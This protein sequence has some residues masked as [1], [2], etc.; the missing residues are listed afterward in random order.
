MSLHQGV[1]Q[2]VGRRA[3]IRCVLG[4]IDKS[5]RLC[6]GVGIVSH[7][8][9]QAR[10][11]ASVEHVLGIRIRMESDPILIHHVTR[12]KYTKY[13]GHVTYVLLSRV[14]G[15]CFHF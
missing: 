5:A 6:Q 9:R 11:H 4:C 12:S 14:G 1:F 8:S 2:S 3:F 15:M 13:A 10:G 7:F